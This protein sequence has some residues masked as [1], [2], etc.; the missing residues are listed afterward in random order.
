MTMNETMKKDDVNMKEPLLT[1]IPLDKIE[2]LENVRKHFDAAKMKELTESIKQR[3]V[4]VPI[5]VVSG[6]KAG[7]YKLVAG[8]R[9]VR[10]ARTLDLKEIPASVVEADA[11][12]QAD[13]Q[14]LVNLQR[15]DLG[16]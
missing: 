2:I 10:A 15:A 11:A 16:P 1:R 6:D 12:A 7:T 13:I 14:L 8:E 9:R 5:I 4:Q 3:G